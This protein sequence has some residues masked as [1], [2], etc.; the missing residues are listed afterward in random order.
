VPVSFIP[1]KESP[2]KTAQASE[3]RI[4]KGGRTENYERSENANPMKSTFNPQTNFIVVFCLGHR[5]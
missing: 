2:S 3:N 1:S 5:G 4:S